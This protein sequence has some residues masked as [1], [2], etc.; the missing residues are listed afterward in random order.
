MTR[1]VYVEVAAIEMGVRYDTLRLSE[2]GAHRSSGANSISK[3]AHGP[4]KLYGPASCA[5]FTF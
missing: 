1:L 4:G 2:Q 5:G 3:K